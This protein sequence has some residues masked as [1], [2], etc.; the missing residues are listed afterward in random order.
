MVFPYAR[1]FSA[2]EL[3]VQELTL[4]VGIPMSSLNDMIN[5]PRHP[6]Q[7]YEALFEGLLLWVFLWFFVRKRK[8]FDGYSGAM[9]AMGYGLVRFF[10]EYFREPDASLGYILR[11]GDPEASTSR[12]VT[13]FNF[14]MGQLLC[15][16]MILAAWIMIA[17]LRKRQAQPAAALVRPLKGRRLRKKIKG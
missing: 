11:L 2:R 16:L 5:L 1:P 12:L 15:V 9:Y 13:P 4:K 14:S 17:T 6:S 3:W 8:P 10:I 7:L